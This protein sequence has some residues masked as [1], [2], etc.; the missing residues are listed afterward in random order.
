MISLFF[1]IVV[2]NEIT[3]YSRNIKAFLDL[4]QLAKAELLK[5][6][7]NKKEITGK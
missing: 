2:T 1:M 5:S 4:S 3:T 6:R 7:S